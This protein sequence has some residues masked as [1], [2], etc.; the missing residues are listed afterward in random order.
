METLE[1]HYSVHGDAWFNASDVLNEEFKTTIK[2]MAGT[3]E[4]RG[5]FIVEGKG[6]KYRLYRE[7]EH[8]STTTPLPL[9]T[10]PPAPQ[11]QPNFYVNPEY[12]AE[13]VS[14][15]NDQLMLDGLYE[16][17]KQTPF[18]TWAVEPAE[19][20]FLFS[21]KLR[22]GETRQTCGYIVRP[23][24]STLFKITEAPHPFLVEDDLPVEPQSVST[25]PEPALK[26]KP[27][28]TPK[29]PPVGH[30]EPPKTHVEDKPLPAGE[31]FTMV[32]SAT[33]TKPIEDVTLADFA[34]RIRRE[35]EWRQAIAQYREVI[36]N[37]E[38][39]KDLKKKLKCIYVSV[40]SDRLR[41]DVPEAFTHNGLIQADFDNHPDYD[42][43]VSQLADD[44]HVRFIFR[45]PSNKVKAFV[46]VAGIGEITTS[47]A[48]KAAF[49]AV[50]THC[51]K[52]RYGGIDGGP[53]ALNSLCFVSHD[54]NAILKDATPLAWD[55]EPPPPPPQPT[56]TYGRSTRPAG[57]GG[58]NED[59]RGFL[60][61][62]GVPITT[63]RTA[64]IHGHATVEIGV[65][66]PWASGHSDPTEIRESHVWES[67]G[68]EWCFKCYH[69]S[70][71]GRGWTEYREVVAPKANPAM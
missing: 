53:S 4:V 50:K 9:H 71:S 69:G 19:R 31:Q 44:P 62:H 43:L 45:S 60:T 8:E 65:P 25:E 24:A 26:V 20:T 1:R 42:K 57:Y 12:P 47:E 64:T 21:F 54:P 46:K 29:L 68:G 17:Y 66:C 3:G 52:Q 27:L 28:P 6:E 38:V 40:R 13:G 5:G 30:S 10:S 51:Y 48:H 11:L 16:R 36:D 22:V 70:C 23:V 32:G 49:R 37:E 59:L 15:E 61:R 14:L 2:D 34:Y 39:A 55:M 56:Y 41:G 18:S 67:S 33:E 58:K 35:P 63:E 7:G